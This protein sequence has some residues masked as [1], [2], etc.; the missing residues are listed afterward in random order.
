M[1]CSSH[2]SGRRVSI[3]ACLPTVTILALLP[4]L[5]GAA[6]VSRFRAPIVA[7]GLLGVASTDALPPLHMNAST[8]VGYSNNP[9]VWRFEDGTYEPVIEHQVAMEVVV[10]IGLIRFVDIGVGLPI[11]LF[12]DG[13]PPPDPNSTDPF[14]INLG[15]VSG[16]GAGDLRIM[17]RLQ[18]ADERS[19]GFGGSFI[20]EFSFNS[21]EVF[22]GRSR[23]FG[24]PGITWRPRVVGS[25]PL[26]FGRLVASLGM[27]IR[28][29]EQIA[30]TGFDHEW[31][32]HVGG[33]INVLRD[34]IPLSAIFELAGANSIGFSGNG[35]VSLELLGAARARVLPELI[36][37]AGIGVGL[38]SGLGTPTTR[39]LFGVSWAP[40]ANDQDNDNV[41]DDIDE[42]PYEGEDYDGFEDGDG[43][44]ELDNDEDAIPDDVDECPDE[45]EDFNEFRDDDGCP[46]AD[47][48]DTDGDGINDLNDRCPADAEDFDSFNDADGCPDIDNDID[49]VPDDEDKCPDEKETINGFEDYDGCPDEGDALT[50]YF[51]SKIEIMETILFESGKAIIK[52]QSERVLDQVA[53]QILAHPDIIKVRIEGHTDSLG[54]DEDN[55]FLSQDR[56]DAVRRYLIGRDVPREKLEAAGFGEEQP[57]DSNATLAGRARNRRVEFII[58]QGEQ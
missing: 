21:G 24:D 42:C 6:D 56:A 51:E 45:P 28:N 35:Q 29:T 34:K 15:T 18:F 47:E 5:V 30:D 50:E 20:S 26:G 43:C 44:P 13:P 46:D 55:L 58:I 41:P 54:P 49:G 16:S 37:T 8:M 57:I 53:L 32:Y 12:Q 31:E 17:P 19:F 11:L 14:N 22:G 36:V 23:Y 10:S 1:R 48:I 2:E 3:R 9:L 4:L 38:T 25:M 40:P 33:E 7:D 27:R 52:T 39:F